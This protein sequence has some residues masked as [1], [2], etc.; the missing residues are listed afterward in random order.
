MSR[1]HA[2]RGSI[3]GLRRTGATEDRIA[4]ARADLRYETLASYIERQV[5]AAPPLSEIQ[6]ARLAALLL[7][8]R[9]SDESEAVPA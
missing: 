4:A 1:S 8:A 5:D 6:R 7:G 9:R 2:A 3:G